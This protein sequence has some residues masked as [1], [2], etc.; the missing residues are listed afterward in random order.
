MPNK[1]RKVP[2]KIGHLQ[3]TNSVLIEFGEK[4]NFNHDIFFV[5]NCQNRSKGSL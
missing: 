4:Q 3:N 1:K 2:F 5:F